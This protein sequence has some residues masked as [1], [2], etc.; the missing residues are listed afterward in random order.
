MKGKNQLKRYHM[1]TVGESESENIRFSLWYSISFAYAKR[2]AQDGTPFINRSFSE[3]NN[4]LS[5][6]TKSSLYFNIF[7][8]RRKRESGRKVCTQ[9]SYPII[10][11]FYNYPEKS[12]FIDRNKERIN[13]YAK[14]SRQTNAYV[15]ISMYLLI[16]CLFLSFVVEFVGVGERACKCYCHAFFS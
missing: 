13:N 9:L 10:G 12:A 6:G 11:A 14:E 7:L 15:C 8:S 1:A 16:S 2:S 3:E 5:V 4:A